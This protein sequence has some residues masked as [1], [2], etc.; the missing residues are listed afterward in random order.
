M[1]DRHTKWRHPCRVLTYIRSLLIEKGGRVRRNISI[2]FPRVG[3]CARPPRTLQFLVRVLTFLSL[4]L[5]YIYIYIYIYI[6]KLHSLIP[7]SLSHFV[8]SY[9][10]P[11][12]TTHVQCHNSTCVR[13]CVCGQSPYSLY[14]SPQISCIHVNSK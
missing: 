11:N 10:N 7:C 3:S 6:W 5:C 14:A 12:C 2:L 8:R 13:V 4:V 9:I 1:V